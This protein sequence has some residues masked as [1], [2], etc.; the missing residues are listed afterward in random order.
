MSSSH[1]HRG[2]LSNT[3]SNWIYSVIAS[4]AANPHNWEAETGKSSAF[5]LLKGF[6]GLIL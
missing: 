5:S 6:K 1:S 3:Q 4:E 2:R